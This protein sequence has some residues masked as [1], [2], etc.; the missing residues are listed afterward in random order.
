MLELYLDTA[1]VEQVRRFNACL[2]I[3]GVTTNP[4][5]LAKSGAGLTRILPA[6]AAALGPGAR[7]HVQ[8]VSQTVGEMVAEAIQID[9]LPYD[10]VVKV[11]VT[12]SGLAAIKQMKALDIQVLATAVYSSHQGFLAAL[13]GADYLAPYVNR[14]DM[15]GADGVGVVAD[16]QLLLDRHRLDCKLLPASFKNTQQVMEVLKLGVGAITIPVDIAAQMFA[17]PAVQPAVNQF[18]QDWQEVFGSKRSFES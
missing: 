14:I 16:L 6:L 15:M 8:V 3:K 13:S 9:A 18:S 17:H 11:P 7:F 4:S 2:P 1:D 10:M 5:I 12:E